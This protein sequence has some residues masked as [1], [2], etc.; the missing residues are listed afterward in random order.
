MNFLFIQI[1]FVIVVLFLGMVFSKPAKMPDKTSTRIDP[2]HLDQVLA[3]PKMRDT[4]IRCLMDKGVC[5]PEASE[6]KRKFS[7]LIDKYVSGFY[8]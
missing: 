6:V 4:Y 5:T 2:A 8:Y 7:I 1:K 3:D